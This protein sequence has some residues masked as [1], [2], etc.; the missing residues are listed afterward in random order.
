M[1]LVSE[2]DKEYLKK[3][4]REK[5]VN[6]MKILIFTHETECHYCKETK[7]LVNEIATT[8]D[9][10]KV[11]IYDIIKNNDKAKEYNIDKVPAIVLISR[12]DYGIRFYGIPSGYEFASL[13]EGVV[14]VSRGATNL[15]EK[16]KN[17]LKSI[18]KPLHIQV[19]V[20][21]TCPYCPRAVRLAH[22][23]AIENDFVRADMVEVSEFPEL[24]EKYD[25]MSV[26]KIVIN[27]KIDFVGALPEEHFLEHVL[28]AL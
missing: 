23:F 9:K 24:A 1:G 22:Q 2:K 8:S 17:Q 26:P 20:T 12:K 3:L 10:V 25:I 4:F 19:F 11:E 21:P 28:M 27:D 15:S 6:E 7:E 14:D 16:T 13:I 5:L 18:N